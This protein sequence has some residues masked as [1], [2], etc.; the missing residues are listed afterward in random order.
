MKN[1]YI[2]ILIVLS[3]LLGIFLS[4]IYFKNI[5]ETEPILSENKTE[6]QSGVYKDLVFQSLKK[7]G[8]D[9]Y[10]KFSKQ[11]EDKIF[12][13][14]CY[15]NGVFTE[16]FEKGC[17]AQGRPLQDKINSEIEIQKEYKISGN[18]D[19]IHY[20]ND[21]LKKSRELVSVEKFF[22]LIN[23]IEKLDEDYFYGNIIEEPQ[24]WSFDISMIN[25]EIVLMSQ[26]Y[27]E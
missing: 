18:I 4:V 3:F 24:K 12:P 13:K 2:L 9:Y 26:V 7:N 27:Q 19:L 1:R 14:Y 17:V 20:D 10:V 21:S 15:N 5:T 8:D 16:D 6:L 25:G 11:Q 22:N 23:K